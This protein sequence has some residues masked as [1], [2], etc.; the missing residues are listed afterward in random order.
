[1]FNNPVAPVERNQKQYMASKTCKIHVPPP[2][3]SFSSHRFILDNHWHVSSS[4]TIR[5]IPPLLSLISFLL[6]I[7]V[8]DENDDDK[9]TCARAEQESG[10]S[11]AWQSIQVSMFSLFLSFFPS[12]LLS[13]L[14]FP[15]CLQWIW[16]LTQTSLIE[17][18]EEKIVPIQSDPMVELAGNSL[19]SVRIRKHNLTFVFYSI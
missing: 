5:T 19:L 17:L 10:S 3:Y 2:P 4:A 12:L 9:Q 13:F 7:E 18:T 14:L 8:C 11:L 6:R 1:M 15:S 16:A